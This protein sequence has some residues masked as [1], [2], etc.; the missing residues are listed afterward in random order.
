MT[1][2]PSALDR[3]R[4]GAYSMSRQLESLFESSDDGWEW[5]APSKVAGEFLCVMFLPAPYEKGPSFGYDPSS[6][7][8]FSP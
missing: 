4:S 7:W 1:P 3:A 2:V 6:S 5:Q 8:I